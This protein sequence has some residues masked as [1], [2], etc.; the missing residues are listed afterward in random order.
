MFDKRSVQFLQVEILVGK[1]KGKQGVINCIIKE[2][3]W[4]YIEGLNCVSMIFRLPLIQKA[5]NQYK[6]N[7]LI[8]LFLRK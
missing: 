6:L 5:K 4:C 1:D 8:D 2:R 3:N 7:C